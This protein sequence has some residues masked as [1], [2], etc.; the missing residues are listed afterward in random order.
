M[1]VISDIDGT[2]A[3]RVNRGPFEWSRLLDDE[4]NAAVVELLRA[5]H[6]RGHEIVFISGRTEDLREQTLLWLSRNVAISGRL[7]MR[8]LKDARTDDVVK[9][10]L[11]VK[12]KIAKKDVLLV[13]DDRDRVVKMWRERLGLTCFQVAEGKF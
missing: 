4:P 13:I 6:D 5:L 7:L 12:L 2:L 3:K 9:A 10:E 11:F 1:V 8:G